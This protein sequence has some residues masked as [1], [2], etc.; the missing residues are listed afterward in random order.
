MTREGTPGHT[1]TS[2]YTSMSAV[3]VWKPQRRTEKCGRT[4]GRVVGA[5]LL[6]A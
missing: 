6:R 3:D 2:T 1:S 5:A 4:K